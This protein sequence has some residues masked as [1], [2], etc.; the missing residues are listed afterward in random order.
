M[1]LQPRDMKIPF[2][3]EQFLEVF[4]QY[5]LSVWPLQLVLYVLAAIAVYAGVKQVRG[6]TRMITS[7]LAFLWIWMGIAYH[8]LFFTS[9]NP[10]A[11]SFGAF[12]VLQGILFL[13]LPFYA[14]NLSF[15]FRPDVEGITGAVFLFF[16]LLL[17]PLIA[18]ALGHVFPA[19][20]TFGLP[21]PTTI[22]TFGLLLWTDKKVPLLVFLLPVLWSV[23]GVSAAFSLGIKEDLGLVVAGL[24]TTFLL[25]KRQRAIQAQGKQQA[26]K[27]FQPR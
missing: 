21:C 6:A 25:L 4:R 15:R 26:Q 22:F 8:L 11:T 27:D 19:T 18:Y 20:P 9:I 1:L 13:L 2:T 12:F 24:I 16:A 17:Y 5:N 14:P 10:A 7:I 23:V 3:T